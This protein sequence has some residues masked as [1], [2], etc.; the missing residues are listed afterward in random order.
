MM[1]HKEAYES[2]LDHLTD[3]FIDLYDRSPNEVERAEL[4]K[5]AMAYANEFRLSYSEWLKEKAKS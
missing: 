1:T 5:E 4:Q 2:Q 3:E